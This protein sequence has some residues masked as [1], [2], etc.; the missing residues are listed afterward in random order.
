MKS[1]TK[2]HH[3]GFEH[4]THTIFIVSTECIFQKT[5]TK[6]DLVLSVSKTLIT[7][8]LVEEIYEA[9]ERHIRWV[10]CPTPEIGGATKICIKDENQLTDFL[11]RKDEQSP[12]P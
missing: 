4:E 9:M 8:F 2:P 12:S 5:K 7:S 3:F 6:H 11:R 1:W 10:D